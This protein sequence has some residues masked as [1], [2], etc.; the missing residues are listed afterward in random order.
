MKRLGNTVGLGISIAMA[1]FI[2]GCG[3]EKG[4]GTGGAGGGSAA[5]GGNGMGGG[6]PSDG[7]ADAPADAPND[8]RADLAGDAVVDAGPP[9]CGPFAD[10]GMPSD[11]GVVDAGAQA[12]FFVTSNT[13]PNANLGGLLGADT[14]CQTVAAA[15]GLGGKTWHAYLSAEHASAG[16]AGG[17]AGTGP[18]NARDRI[19]AGP[20]YNVRGVM[21]AANLTD[22]HSR[23]GDA[24]VFLDEH[25]LMINGQWTGSPTPNE[26]D[27]LTGTNAD[28]TVAVGKTCLDWTSDSAV[29]DG[30]VDGGSLFVARIGHTDG[31]GGR[32]NTTPAP[33]NDVTSWNSA[34]DT[35]SCAD[36]RARGGVGHIYCFAIN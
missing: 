15:A 29:P 20:W 6:T 21:V 16:D 17:D 8:A 12:S 2:A 23:R 10:G 32:C 27:I 31:F 25:G 14:R 9:L 5:T 30:G 36:I 7:G 3:S 18:V 11:A 28:G 35:V 19:G 22:L 24:T 33:P 1:A 34:H 4:G 26:H 13:A